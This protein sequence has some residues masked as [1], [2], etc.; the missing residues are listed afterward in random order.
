MLN[1]PQVHRDLTSL[2]I[3]DRIGM[4]PVMGTIKSRRTLG[5]K[6]ISDECCVTLPMII[7]IINILYFPLFSAFLYVSYRLG[8]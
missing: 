3:K 8:A 4:G 6:T 1:I 7:I 2:G 5:H